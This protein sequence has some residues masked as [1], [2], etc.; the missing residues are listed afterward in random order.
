M[1]GL[2]PRPFKA[3]AFGEQRGSE[4]AGAAADIEH[5]CFGSLKCGAKRA[6]GLTPPVPVEAEG[7]QVIQAVVARRNAVE[8]HGERVTNRCLSTSERFQRESTVNCAAAIDFG[9]AQAG[10]RRRDC[11]AG[12]KIGGR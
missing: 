4:V 7:E 12:E 11:V 1:A 5:A 3:G 6:C 2:K 9:P 8:D 10:A